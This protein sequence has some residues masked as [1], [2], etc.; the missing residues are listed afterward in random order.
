M[1]KK[2]NPQVLAETISPQQHLKEKIKKAIK[3]PGFAL[4]D[5]DQTCVT[6]GKLLRK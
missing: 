2:V 6:F 3:F 1:I 4:L 5:I